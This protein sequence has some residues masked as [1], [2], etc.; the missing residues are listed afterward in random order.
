MNNDLIKRS[1]VEQMLIALGGCDASDK[2]AEGWDKAI[3]A[4]II[5]LGELDSAN[6]WIMDAIENIIKHFSECQ[7]DAIEKW[8]ECRESESLGWDKVAFNQR[9]GFIIDEL[10]GRHKEN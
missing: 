5:E 10:L 2:E 8:K 4:A 9:M 1:D 3:D 7:N 6:E